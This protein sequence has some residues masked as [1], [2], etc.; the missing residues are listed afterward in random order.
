MKP[1]LLPSPDPS[2]HPPKSLGL[3]L[4]G[5]DFSVSDP[6]RLAPSK[7]WMYGPDVDEE[8]RNV[9]GEGASGDEW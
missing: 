7:T 9:T 5:T 8:T 3:S 1:H 2:L 4:C 6:V